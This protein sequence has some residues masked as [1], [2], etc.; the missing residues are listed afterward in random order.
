MKTYNFLNLK[1]SAYQHISILAH[2]FLLLQSCASIPTNTHTDFQRIATGMGPEDILLDTISCSKARLLISCND[3]RLKGEAPN[4][5]IYA[6]DLEADSAFSYKLNRKGEPEGH[7]FHPHGFDLIRQN[8]KVYLYIVSHDD[9][10]DKHY[11]YKYEVSEKEL[12]FVT[13]YEN[14]LMN[15]PNTVVAL[16][17]GGF[18]TSI[19]QG[20]RGDIMALLFRAKTGSIVYC[21]EQGGWAHVAKKLAYPN[22]LYISPQERYL[23]ASTT[24]QDQVFKYVIKP[25][26][27]L[28]N[29]DK[30]TALKGGDNIRLGLGKEIL[31][32]AHLQALK[33]V[34]HAKKPEKL[35]PSVVYG[36]NMDTGEK[37]VIY[38][39]KGEQIS[40][41]STA[42][43]YK[44]H[45]Y[46]SQ[47]FQPFVL[48]T[49]FQK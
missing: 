14:P 6:I 47:V 3:H 28:V 7:D 49:K 46:I 12:L 19:D 15:S 17:G 38:A 22:G 31:I 13:A 40:A 29:Q 21:D 43:V 10:K 42:V 16:S 32:T 35:S 9:K 8:G 24:R 30:V 41:A 34:G 23:Y 18:Y 36:V 2:L 27:N 4:G 25:D 44:N 26:G 48:K 1:S 20:K 39:N 45:I 11:V 37:R 33:F 5:G